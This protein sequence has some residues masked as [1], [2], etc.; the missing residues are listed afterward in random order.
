MGRQKQAVPRRFAPFPEEPSE[1]EEP[2]PKRRRRRAPPSEGD[3]LRASAP[4]PS[5]DGAVFFADAALEE[6]SGDAAGAR[7]ALA[8][9]TSLQL[10]LSAA[11][12]GTYVAT[13]LLE[14]SIEARPCCPLGCFTVSGGAAVAA[15]LVRLIGTGGRG[16]RL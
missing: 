12:G 10:C 1:E 7:E 11:A 2:Q 4:L 8:A 14:T 16:V 13:A 6:T 5:E 9:A 15:A 3:V